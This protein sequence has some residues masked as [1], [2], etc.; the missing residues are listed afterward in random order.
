MQFQC[1]CNNAVEIPVKDEYILDDDTITSILQGEFLS[2]SCD[3]CGKILKPEIPLTFRTLDNE[4][5]SFIP[6]NERFST[7]ETQQLDS[8]SLYVIGYPELIEYIHILSKD[9]KKEIIEIIK[10]Q[11]IQKV[12]DPSKTVILFQDYV[13]SRLIF[14]IHGLKDNEIAVMKIPYSLYQ[15]IEKDFRKLIQNDPYKTI[16]EKPYI[17]VRKHLAD[18]AGE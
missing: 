1:Y 15:S 8:N 13:D 2:T 11:I 6:E 7:F 5:V 18:E 14:H 3:R 16:V 17:S 10:L 12:P 9:F 4:H